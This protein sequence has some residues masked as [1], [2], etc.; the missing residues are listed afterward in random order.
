ML[1]TSQ[2]QIPLPLIPILPPPPSPPLPF[3]PLPIITIF[4]PSPFS[5]FLSLFYKLKTP[6]DLPLPQVQPPSLP[7]LPIPSLNSPPLPLPS[8]F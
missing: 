1:T 7:L 2:S 3:P 8:F 4:V 5:T 6:F